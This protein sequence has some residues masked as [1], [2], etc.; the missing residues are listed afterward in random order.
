MSKCV[1]FIDHRH[2]IRQGI[3]LYNFKTGSI[4]ISPLSKMGS[5][6]HLDVRIFITFFIKHTLNERKKMAR[7]YVVLATHAPGM[8]YCLRIRKSFRRAHQLTTH[9]YYDCDCVPTNV[10]SYLQA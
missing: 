3:I 6:K 7:D 9:Q 1:V 10:P 8:T 5:L 2:S 4:K